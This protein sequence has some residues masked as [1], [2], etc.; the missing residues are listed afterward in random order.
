MAVSKLK[1]P[2]K[3]VVWGFIISIFLWLMI[4]GFYH[5]AF[6][7]M[8]I[9]MTR[10]WTCPINPK[11]FWQKKKEILQVELKVQNSRKRPIEVKAIAEEITFIDGK[12]KRLGKF[13]TVKPQTAVLYND[14]ITS[15]NVQFPIPKENS[16]ILAV[17]SCQPVQKENKPEMV[18][19][20]VV[21]SSAVVIAASFYEEKWEPKPIFKASKKGEKIVVT[22]GNDSPWI[23]EGT[24]R[25]QE[26]GEYADDK[27]HFFAPPNVKRQFFFVD[28]NYD[29]V[30]LDIGGFKHMLGRRL[31]QF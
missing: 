12:I 11:Y 24:I 7:A 8:V 18:G 20:T 2:G 25:F 13:L 29:G 5:L 27:L 3:G 10:H 28:H 17:F 30:V 1:I 19:A 6:G 26:G 21:T 23:Y 16:S 9:P 22:V 15:F 4:F 31:Q 14:K